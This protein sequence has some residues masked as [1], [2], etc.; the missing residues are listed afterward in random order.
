MLSSDP[1]L[2]GGGTA[3]WSVSSN[4]LGTCGVWQ[5]VFWVSGVH[6]KKGQR[7][8]NHLFLG[9]VKCLCLASHL[10]RHTAKV[11]T[12]DDQRRFALSLGCKSLLSSCWRWLPFR[13]KKKKRV[14]AKHVRFSQIKPRN[15]FFALGKKDD[16]K[17]NLLTLCQQGER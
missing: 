2:S 13:R 11:I 7:R 4:L 12:A 14:E 3:F 17:L 9:T 6:H 10:S 5:S 8:L 16:K 15:P 1:R